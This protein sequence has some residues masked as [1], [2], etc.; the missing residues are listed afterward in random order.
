VSN[1]ERRELVT[2]CTTSD[3]A[4]YPSHVL[5]EVL[6][7]VHGKVVREGIDH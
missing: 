5:V 6:V 3:R 2:Q 4:E 7:D 1:H